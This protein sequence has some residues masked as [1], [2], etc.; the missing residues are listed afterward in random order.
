MGAQQDI[1]NITRQGFYIDIVIDDQGVI[2]A[3]VFTKPI[4]PS[5]MS[6]SVLS[7]V[8]EIGHD[9]DEV[10]STLVKRLNKHITMESKS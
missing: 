2:S 6:T 7:P 10:L 1:T 5:G 9:L 8:N 4:Q 3:G